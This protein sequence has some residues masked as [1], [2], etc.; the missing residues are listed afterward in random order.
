MLYLLICKQFN[1]FV[2][3]TISLIF[4][5]Y[6]VVSYKRFNLYWLG[7]D[8]GFSVFFLSFQ[9]SHLNLLVSLPWHF[10]DNILIFWS[11]A[12]VNRNS[13]LDYRGILIWD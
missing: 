7:M 8:N 5:F 2:T 13:S 4:R 10:K 12:F 11:Q 1:G 6:E 3:P 9:R